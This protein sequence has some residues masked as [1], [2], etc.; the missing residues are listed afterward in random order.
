MRRS[1]SLSG[2]RERNSIPWRPVPYRS[3]GPF[4]D[5]RLGLEEE[6]VAGCNRPHEVPGSVAFD[7]IDHIDEVIRRVAD[8]GPIEVLTL[9]IRSSS[10]MGRAALL[11]A[12]SMRYF[13]PPAV[14][15]QDHR[16]SN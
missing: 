8:H 12:C 1:R 9:A 4:P 15:E 6:R 14:R 11:L 2:V 13:D 16:A 10:V 5:C 7:A 3:R